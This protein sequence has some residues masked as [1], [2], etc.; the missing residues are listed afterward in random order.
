[1]LGMDL[2]GRPILA[3]VESWPGRD[4]TAM[5]TTWKWDGSRWNAVRSDLP[6]GIGSA[7]VYES[8]LRKMVE[9]A[10]GNTGMPYTMWGWDSSGWAELHP[11][12]VPSPGYDI[13]LLSWDPPRHQLVAVV[14]ETFN[15]S[16]TWTFDG[17]TW[18]RSPTAINP[19]ARRQAGMAYDPNTSRVVLYGGLPIAAGVPTPRNDTWTW[20]GTGWTEQH[21]E[22][23]PGGRG[24]DLAYDAATSQMMLLTQGLSGDL[25][26]W[27]WT[28]TTWTQLHP[29]T[30]P[31][32][33]RG[34]L[35]TYDAVRG[36]LVF[37]TTLEFSPGTEHTWTYANG[38]WK[39]ASS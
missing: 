14:P 7:I 23:T 34:H 27:F 6:V 33:P 12:T 36:E 16:S 8:H 28:G 1:M 4:T 38:S 17:V 19:P 21:P 13:A 24:A 22:T 31:P 20:D 26:M 39:E 30:I 29:S 9:L 2:D 35:M 32:A 3:S 15:T 37:F 5:T 18:M 11:A 25:T 10:G